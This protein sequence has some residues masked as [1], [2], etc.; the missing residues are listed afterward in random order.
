MSVIFFSVTFPL[1]YRTN[2]ASNIYKCHVRP[3]YVL[4]VR[5][6]EPILLY[7]LPSIFLLSNLLTVYALCRSRS[8]LTSML[9]SDARHVEIRVN[10][11]HSSRKQRQLTIM[12]ITV[13]L[14]FYV[15]TTPAMFVYVTE[16]T[17]PKHR[18][19]ATIKRNFLLSQ[20]T[21]VLLQLNN[22]VSISA[23][24]REQSVENV[25][26]FLLDEFSLLL[27]RWPTFSASH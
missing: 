25:V 15:F 22:A 7:A 21:V 11:V 23:R 27:V 1:V 2:A 4:I 9:N 3:H 10:D 5:I 16:S 26:F 13:S 14:S 8:Q 17:R 12:L 19:L 18:D 6:Y 24:L 20:I